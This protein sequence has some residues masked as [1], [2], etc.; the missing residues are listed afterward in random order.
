[1]QPDLLSL[2]EVVPVKTTPKNVLDE[3]GRTGRRA[4]NGPRR[5]R[6]APKDTRGLRSVTGTAGPAR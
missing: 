4:A 3:E 5:A 2:R 1:M 6:C